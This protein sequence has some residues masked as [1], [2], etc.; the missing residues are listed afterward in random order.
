MQ[1][2]AHSLERL[3]AQ[4]GLPDKPADIERF[5]SAH[6]PLARDT[7]LVEA[8]FWT[9]AQATF[10]RELIVEDAD[11]AVAVEELNARLH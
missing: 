6:R 7:A 8:G 10:L 11:W 5:I 9:P 2:F 4:L 1:A 3:F